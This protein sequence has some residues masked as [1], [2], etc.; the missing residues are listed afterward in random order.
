[1]EPAIL[2]VKSNM[3]R[4]FSIFVVLALSVFALCVAPAPT[5]AEACA[6]QTFGDVTIGI[7]GRQLIAKQAGKVL[8]RHELPVVGG[9]SRSF[10]LR[11]FPKKRLLFIEWTGGQA[12]TRS[13]FQTVSLLA[14]S[15]TPEGI[16]PR[17]EWVIRQ[18]YHGDGPARIEADR[19][20]R[21]EE[22]DW[23]VDVILEGTRRIG[24]EAG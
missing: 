22:H 12:G 19:T 4:A 15:I 16:T 1:M 24:T 7:E 17:G 11:A 5:R 9:A 18:G 14:F 23:G 13:I 2:G 8:A 20:W 3:S 10:A 21:L 6:A